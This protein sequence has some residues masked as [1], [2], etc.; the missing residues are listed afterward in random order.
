M[1]MWNEL[2]IM[3][4]ELMK[5]F[6]QKGLKVIP[7]KRVLQDISCQIIGIFLRCFFNGF[8]PVGT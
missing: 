6:A 3:P 8:V 1:S 4:L 2:L 7:L 5:F